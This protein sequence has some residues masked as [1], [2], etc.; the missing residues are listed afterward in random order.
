M[1]TL[2]IALLALLFSLVSALIGIEAENGNASGKNYNLFLVF[3]W[4][5]FWWAIISVS[6]FA[7]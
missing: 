4:L 2:T 6:A 7:K 3:S 1:S 5:A